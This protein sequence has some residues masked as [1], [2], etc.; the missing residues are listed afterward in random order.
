MLD[1]LIHPTKTTSI[2]SSEPLST[3]LMQRLQALFYGLNTEVKALSQLSESLSDTISVVVTDRLECFDGFAAEAVNCLI[4]IVPQSLNVPSTGQFS[5]AVIYK[6]SDDETIAVALEK[7]FSSLIKFTVMSTAYLDTLDINSCLQFRN[8][9]YLNVF[10][11]SF[12]RLEYLSNGENFIS[13]LTQND[14]IIININNQSPETQQPFRTLQ[15]VLKHLSKNF[16]G[17]IFWSCLSQENVPKNNDFYIL[18]ASTA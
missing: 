10:H 15:P 6:R 7:I 4:L 2:Y 13:Q 16:A 1:T 11:G 12:E 18:Q 9:R 14:S 3:G 5:T 8:H 17:D